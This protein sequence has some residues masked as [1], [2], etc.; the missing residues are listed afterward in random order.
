MYGGTVSAGLLLGR[1]YELLHTLGRGGM[2]QVWEARDLRLKRRV[3]VKILSPAGVPEP[4]DLALFRREAEIG[5]MLSHPGITTVFDMGS[6]SHDGRTPWYIVMER[7]VG[8]NFA[9]ELARH[10]GGLPV[11]QVVDLAGQV[12]AALGAAHAQ[13][14]VHRDVK[15][16]NL[17]LQDSGLVKICDFGISRLANATHLLTGFQVAGTLPYMAPEQ[18]AT[19]AVDHRSDLYALGCVLYELLAGRTWVDPGAD[20]PAAM[21]QHFEVAPPRPAASRPDIPEELDRLVL[22]LLAKDP[23]D[24]PADA[25]AVAARLRGI[26]RQP[27]RGP[28]STD[29]TTDGSTDAQRLEHRT[30]LLTDAATL[31]RTLYV[32]RAAEVADSAYRLQLALARRTSDPDPDPDRAAGQGRASHQGGALGAAEHAAVDAPELRTGPVTVVQSVGA[33]VSDGTSSWG[34]GI[35]GFFAVFGAVAGLTSQGHPVIPLRYLDAYETSTFGNVAVGAFTTGFA[36]WAV[37]GLLAGAA[38]LLRRSDRVL[39]DSEGLHIRRSTGSRRSLDIPWALVD[40]VFVSNHRDKPYGKV[41][42]RFV[43]GHAPTGAW[44]ELNSVTSEGGGSFV[45]YEKNWGDATR[46]DPRKL[47]APIQL[48]AGRRWRPTTKPVARGSAASGRRR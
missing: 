2:G 15:P 24:R 10:P 34:Q 6:P 46:V 39:I 5:A 1:R 12:A 40:A 33:M 36:A 47:I 26:G 8:H 16:A 45:V 7:L 43:P 18:F 21:Y 13:G 48:F 23:A 4:R 38:A 37:V 19:L 42:L 31:F 44:C 35:G 20:W 3:A 41:H 22:D 29:G 28:G 25:V 14:V 27:R 17:F 32:R 30:R 9:G 11:E